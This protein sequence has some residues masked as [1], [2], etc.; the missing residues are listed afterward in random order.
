MNSQL[1]SPMISLAI[2]NCFAS[3]RWIEPKEWAAVIRDFGIYCVEAS[4]DNECDPLYSTPD[5]LN[6][7]IK[8]VL[9]VYEQTGVRVVNLYSGHGTYATTGLCHPDVR[10]RDRILNDWLKVM[11]GVAG[12]LG[13]GLGFACHAFSESILQDP[14]EYSKA[15]EDLY[16]RLAEL[17]EFANKNGTQSIG[18]EQMYTPHMVPWTI[19]GSKKLLQEVY[20]HSAQPFYLTID[21]GHMSGQRKFLY[22]DRNKVREYLHDYRKKG[23]LEGAWLGPKSSYLRLKELKD[24]SVEEEE[25]GLR[26]IEEEMKAKPYLFA[27]FEDGDPYLWLEQLGCYSPII[28]LQQ[29]SGLASAHLPFTKKWN[30]T[31]IIH[32][33]KVL[34]T[35]AKSYS[36]PLQDG[37]PPRCLNIYL[38]IEVFSATADL[39]EDIISRLEETVAYWRQWVPKDGL[40]LNKMIEIN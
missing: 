35:L 19:A 9:D 16:V 4:A 3:R 34:E 37:M 1:Y 20:R 23:G 24:C 5:F 14:I 12:R 2:D 15:E 31:G 30:E 21:T 18:L 33:Q 22:P 10:I 25:I 39:P 27:S 13:A 11:A 26:Q 38:T 36:Q 17:A 6:D 29:T 28:H 8:D 40:P 7:W 32:P